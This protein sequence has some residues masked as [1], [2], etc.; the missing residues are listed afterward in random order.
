MSYPAYGRNHVPEAPSALLTLHLHDGVTPLKKV[1]HEP[2]VGVLDQSDLEAQRIFTDLLIRGA[3]RANALGSCTAN[4]TVSALSNLLP[5]TT[6]LMLPKK[7]AHTTHELS[8]YQD[9]VNAERAAVLFYHACTAQ[10]GQPAEEWPPTDCGSSGAYV[11][12]ELQHLRLAKGAKIAS[13]ADNIVSLLQQGG[14][15][16]GQPFF[17][18]AEEPDQFGFIDGDGSPSAIEALIA[19]GV[20]GGH[21]TYISAIE[22]LTLLPSGHVDPYNTVLRERN[23]WSASW[24]DNG[25]YR[26]HLSTHIALQGSSDFRLILPV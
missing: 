8:G 5:S 11:V 15:I 2:K 4:A 26:C 23:S 22:K 20:A 25:S 24:G 12:Q 6:F 19:S 13:G 7:I 16:V 17:N 9:V 14:L 10:T 1:D 18:A 3:K 21:E